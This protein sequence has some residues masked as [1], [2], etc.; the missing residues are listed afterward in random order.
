MKLV[1]QRHA[2]DQLWVESSQ[3]LHDRDA[4]LIKVASSLTG[5]TWHLSVA[6]VNSNNFCQAKYTHIQMSSRLKNN[7]YLVSNLHRPIG[8]R[9]EVLLGIT[10]GHLWRQVHKK[11]NPLLPGTVPWF[12]GSC[13]QPGLRQGVVPAEAA[14]ANEKHT[15]PLTLN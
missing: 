5:S 11:S 3:P 8:E 15:M 14:L 1:Y 4:R 7:W 12:Q 10:L 2:G 13:T 9:N 6:L